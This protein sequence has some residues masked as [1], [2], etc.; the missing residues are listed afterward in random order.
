[1]RQRA[2]NSGK[3]LFSALDRQALPAAA[4]AF[5]KQADLTSNS[6]THQN[7]RCPLLTNAFGPHNRHRATLGLNMILA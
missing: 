5:L 7:P 6:K 2:R 3:V 4:T 1:M